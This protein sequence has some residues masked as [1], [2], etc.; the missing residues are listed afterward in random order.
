M[1]LAERMFVGKNKQM[2]QLSRMQTPVYNQAIYLLRHDF[3]WWKHLA[4]GWKAYYSTKGPT[5]LSSFSLNAMMRWLPMYR[6]AIPTCA[7]TAIQRAHDA[8]KSWRKSL[9]A[10]NACKAPG[11]AKTFLKGDA[12]EPCQTCGYTGKPGMPRY[13]KRG[14][15]SAIYFTYTQ[16]SIKQHRAI[17]PRKSGIRSI[18]VPRLGDQAIN[19]SRAAVKQI[20]V[21]PAENDGF[22]VEFI[23]D[24][25]VVH[26]EV[27]KQNIM[28]IDLGMNELATVVNNLGDQPVCFSGRCKGGA[29]EIN[30]WYSKEMARLESDKTRSRPRI[31]ELQ[32]KY[33][34]LSRDEWKEW[35]DVVS[36][37]RRMAFITGKR[38]RRIGKI[39]HAISKQIIDLAVSRNI[40]KI[41]IGHNRGQKQGMSQGK[42]FDQAFGQLPI[43]KLVSMI[44]YKAA[45]N[46]IE[47]V[48]VSEEFTSKASFLDG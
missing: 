34:R 32:R 33:P 15:R 28:G 38:N 14:Q 26:H 45:M 2:D 43:F 48:E 44:R 35:H 47:V 10:F 17:F 31:A 3:F 4:T 13:V 24:V 21:I 22:L 5:F 1:Q 23:H 41:I 29:K 9:R 46:G 8:W 19:D 42:R 20:R 16:F 39:F 37:T 25:D 36:S 30:Q 12:H 18:N 11:H 40:G 6:D 27:D 7:M